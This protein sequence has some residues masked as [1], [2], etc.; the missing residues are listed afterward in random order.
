MGCDAV[1]SREPLGGRRRRSS[2]ARPDCGRWP[3]SGVWI[4]LVERESA[5]AAAQRVESA[6]RRGRH[7]PLGRLDVRGEGQHRRRRPGDHRRRVR[8]SRTTSR[9]DAPVVAALRSAGAVVVGK[10]NMDQFATGLV[11]MR[12]PYGICPNAHWAGLVSGGS[13]SGVRGCRRRG[14]VDFAL[15]TD[16][17]GSGRVPAACNGIVGLKP[18]RGRISTSGVV[19][20]CRS[21]DCVSVF[22]RSVDAA[23]AA[24]DL[25]SGRSGRPVESGGAERSSPVV[26]LRVGVPHR[27]D[28]D[29]VERVAANVELVDVDLA[30][31]LEAGAC[32]MA[33][34][35]SP[36]ATRPSVP[37]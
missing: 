2:V 24:V 11:G 26:P 21:L 22:A 17:A 28:F 27:L 25:A 31:F 4:S 23:A 7:L 35:S 3:G 19:P 36:S 37:S 8:P 13:S 6:R 14:L 32:C 9:P 20:A 1:R 33:A 16:T 10:T 15:G 30:P 18:T 34:R 29:G 5:L 12:S